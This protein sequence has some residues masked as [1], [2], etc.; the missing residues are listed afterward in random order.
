M[1]RESPGERYAEDLVGR[2]QNTKGMGDGSRRDKD[3]WT[4]G[5]QRVNVV[6]RTTDVID[7]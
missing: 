5:R 4:V 2:Q 3:A 1:L 7:N 6:L